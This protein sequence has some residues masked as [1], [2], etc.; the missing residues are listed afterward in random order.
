MVAGMK[1]HASLFAGMCAMLCASLFTSCASMCPAAKASPSQVEHVVLVWLK[2]AGD[3]G[4]RSELIASAKGFQKQIPGILSISAGAPLPSERPVV[5]DS[6]DI[7]L[8]M[9]FESKEALAAYETH[10]VH[11]KAVKEALAP[12]S[13]KLQV[14]DVVVR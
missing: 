12:A 9:R 14:Y 10:P 4:K 2:D 5:D 1:S 11:V 6:F 13:R 7:G 3:E 8:V